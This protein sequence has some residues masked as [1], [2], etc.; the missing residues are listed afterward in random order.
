M[1]IIN[2]DFFSHLKPFKKYTTPKPQWQLDLR[3]PL[4]C[5]DNVFDGVF[6]EHVL[7]HLYIDDAR[8]LLKEIY[9][10]LKSG[11]TLRLSVP[12]LAFRVAEYLK[13]KQDSQKR[14]LASE[15]IRKLTQEYLH[16][17]VWDYDR[18]YYELNEL[19]FVNIEQSSFK[20]GRNS[21]LLFDLEDRAYESL[22]VEASKPS[23]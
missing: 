15:H 18:L 17:S 1:T 8:A 22:Y 5:A 2:A 11:G 10:I 23:L 9:R 6:S 12:D 14:F 21:E 7:E 19:G 16:L 13:D 20:K 3:Y 4:L